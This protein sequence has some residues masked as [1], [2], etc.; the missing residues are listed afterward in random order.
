MPCP[1][2]ETAPIPSAHF[3]VDDAGNSTPL[4]TRTIT[5]TNAAAVKPFGTIDTPAPGQV[6]SGAAFKNWA[7]ALTPQPANIA[8]GGS[9][10]GVF[11]DGVRL[12]G[13][14]VYG[15]YRSDIAALFPG[16]T[17]S[18]GPAA[19]YLLDTTA[20]ADGVHTI[21]WSVR[22]SA[23]RVDGIGSRF[24][25]IANG[26]PLPLAEP[27]TAFRA[28]APSREGIWLRTGYDEAAS[29]TKVEGSIEV[30]QSERIEIHL[31][32]A[33][34]RGCLVIGDECSEMPAGSTLRDNVFYWQIGAAFRGEFE[35]RF[36]GS[37]EL[38]VRVTVR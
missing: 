34:E 29:L 6:I 17:N 26:T 27:K 38:P 9:P 14:P 30:P 21:A 1:P 13:N 2:A 12:A 16:Y 36:S 24:F 35:L 23:G 19:L 22:D 11:I 10:F 37:E 8:S 32:G 5:C 15:T 4:G 18:N 3:A 28:S 33:V 20:I 7:W 25:E 31:P